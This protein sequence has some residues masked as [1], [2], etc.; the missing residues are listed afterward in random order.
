MNDAFKAKMTYCIVSI[1]VVYIYIALL[2]VPVRR[3]SN[4][5]DPCRDKRT[6]FREGNEALG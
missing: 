5:R 1:G 3:A 2:E 4:M 6:V